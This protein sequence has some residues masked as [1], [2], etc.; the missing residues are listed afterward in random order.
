MSICWNERKHQ[1]NESLIF[2]TLKIEKGENEKG[3][4][5]FF[6]LLFPTQL[7]DFSKK[8]RTIIRNLWS[9]VLITTSKNKQINTQHKKENEKQKQQTLTKI[10]LYISKNLCFNYQ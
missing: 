2:R 5:A 8:R 7:H 1:S 3:Y 6:R 9:Q 10:R 4:R